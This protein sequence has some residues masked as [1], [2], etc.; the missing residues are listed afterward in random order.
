MLSGYEAHREQT[1]HVK[2][3]AQTAVQIT[4][5]HPENSP[6]QTNVGCAGR[7]SCIWWSLYVVHMFHGVMVWSVTWYVLSGVV[8]H[9]LSPTAVWLLPCHR[10]L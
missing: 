1:C 10:Y 7:W 6:Q 2:S 4:R 8:A 5:H 9:L 3:D